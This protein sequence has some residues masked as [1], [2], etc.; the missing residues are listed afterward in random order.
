MAK[1]M[2]GGA[3]VETNGALPAPG[4][5]APPFMLTRQDLSEVTLEAFA[6][7]KKILNIFPSIDTG[8]CATSVRT[9]N[10][11]ASG[12]TGVVVLNVSAD[13]PFAAKRFCGAEGLD[14]VE[15]LSTFR[16][17]FAT[18]YGVEL[19]G[20]KMKGLN[21][22]AVIVLDGQDRVLHTELV[23]DIGQEPNYSAALAA[24]G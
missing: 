3:P 23:P 6:G 13:L 8:I 16:S 17:T 19:T 24:L 14:G 1:T 22:R 7:K 5:S 21:A 12:R 15:T 10:A 20:S 4:E 9:F 2:L 11:K 18:D